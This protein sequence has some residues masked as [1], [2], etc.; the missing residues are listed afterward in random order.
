MRSKLEFEAKIVSF[1]TALILLAGYSILFDFWGFA[2]F[3]LAIGIFLLLLVAFKGFMLRQFLGI[4]LIFVALVAGIFLAFPLDPHYAPLVLVLIA[5]LIAFR[6]KTVTFLPSLSG[7]LGLFSLQ[8]INMDLLSRGIGALSVRLAALI[9]VK[10]AIDDVGYLHVYFSRARLPMFIDQIKILLQLYVSIL[11]GQLVLLCLLDTR[12]RNILKHI[13]LAVF[14]TILMPTITLVYLI[15]APST[16]FFIP[17]EWWALLLPLTYALLLSSFTPDA[18]LVIK[19]SSPTIPFRIKRKLPNKIG[20]ISKKVVR[21]A[22]GGLLIIFFV[23]SLLFYIPFEVRHDPVVI[24]DESHSEWEP[25]WTDYM[26][27]YAKDPVSGTNNY[28]GLLNILSSI[29]DCTLIVDKLEKQPAVRS[30]KTILSKE[31]SIQMLE[32]MTEGR[33]GVLI[34]KCV[35][36]EYSKSEIDTILTFVAKG[37]GL[38]LISDHTDIYGMGT[39]LNPIAEQLGYRFLP[40]A[41]LDIYSETRGMVTQKNEFPTFISRFLTGDYFWE[42]GCSLEKLTSSSP[43]LFEVRSHISCFAQWRNETSAFF[44]NRQTTEEIKLNSNFQ[45]HLI[46]SAVKYGH[47]KV[48]LMSDSTP[49]NNGLIGYGEHAQLFMGMIEYTASENNFDRSLFLILM[50]G[51]TSLLIILNRKK[52]SEMIILLIVL[53][54]LSCS[55]AYRFSPYFIQFPRLKTEPRA[56]AIIMPENYYEYYFLGSLNVSKIMDKYFRQNLTAIL[57]P[58]PPPNEWLQICARTEKFVD[59]YS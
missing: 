34:L 55:L 3:F 17:D 46:F 15:Q 47:G 31:I 21:N 41:I 30:V 7:L 22:T 5:S 14:F 42:T 25:T 36:K 6:A 10:C 57:F 8:S 26:E 54:L 49:F 50:L 24:I 28:F 51:I 40:S 23:L 2:Q 53:V 29:Y 48:I 12:K 32:N 27:T 35:T 11:V 59:I 19:I 20:R 38:I 56:A 33:R 44:L 13:F 52:A 4:H 37:N 1:S 9:S 39:Y 45:A 16:A 18:R 43:T 58:G